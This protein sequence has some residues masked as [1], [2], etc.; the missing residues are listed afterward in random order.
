M[1][2]HYVCVTG[3]D[4]LETSS[5]THDEE[6]V[7]SICLTTDRGEGQVLLSPREAALLAMDILGQAGYT[8]QLTHPTGEES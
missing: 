8:A 3:S 7:V 6:P 4:Y 2:I 5:E 1:P